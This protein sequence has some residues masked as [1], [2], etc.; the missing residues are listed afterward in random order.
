MKSFREEIR[1]LS[2]NSDSKIE[3]NKSRKLYKI[4]SFLNSDGLLQVCGGLGKS[5]LS[6]SEAHPLVFPKQSNISEAI[7]R[8]CHENVA[9]GGRG[10]T[11]NNLRQNGLWIISANVVV[12]GMIYRC[13]NCC[14]LRG[15]FDVQKMADLPKVRH[16]E[17][18]PLTH[19][20]V[21]MFGIHLQ[22]KT[23]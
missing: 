17:I 3:V 7:I 16:L 20:G 13:V 4:D 14:K 11:L 21:D 8:W 22:G 2:A 1:V 9:Q 5:R 12:R 19:C 23:I 6:R 15:K 18:P 10:M